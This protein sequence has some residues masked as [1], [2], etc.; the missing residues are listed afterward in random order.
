MRAT[1]RRVVDTEVHL[2]TFGPDGRVIAFPSF[3]DAG[4]LVA[5]MKA[6]GGGVTP[7]L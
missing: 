5:A 6:P 3:V 2:F 1:G 7:P 4:Q